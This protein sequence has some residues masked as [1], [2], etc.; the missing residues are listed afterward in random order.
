[1]TFTDKLKELVG[2]ATPA[3]W[4]VIDYGD[5]LSGAITIH[6]SDE[7]RICFMPTIQHEAD[8]VLFGD[9]A[10]LICH[11]VNHAEDIVALVEVLEEASYN[12]DNQDM[13]HEQY[14]VY[15]AG[16]ARGVLSRLEAKP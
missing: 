14:R 13:N 12:F 4:T 10:A 11:L 6:W 5:D 7:D 3:P 15:V 8:R 16:L 2:K 1:M 9:N